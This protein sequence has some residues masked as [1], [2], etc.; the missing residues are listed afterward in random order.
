M[1]HRRTG[2]W[3]LTIDPTIEQIIPMD[4]EEENSVRITIDTT[5]FQKTPPSLYNNTPETHPTIPVQDT[6]SALKVWSPNG[7]IRR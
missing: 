5:V 1:P 6:S 4:W 2:D 3:C 7:E